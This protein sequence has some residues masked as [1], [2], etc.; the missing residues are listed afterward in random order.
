MEEQLILFDTAKLAKEK[1]FTN[2]TVLSCWLESRD[3]KWNNAHTQRDKVPYI[4]EGCYFILQPT[5]SLLQRWLREKHGL[6]LCVEYTGITGIKWCYEI[7]GRL[8]TYTGNSYEETLE[9]G[10]LEALKLI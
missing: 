3:P 10:L 9:A 1:G 2:P 5:Q 6:I 8:K 7:H 4:T